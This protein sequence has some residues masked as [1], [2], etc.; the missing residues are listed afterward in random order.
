MA[1]D[2]Q[3]EQPEKDAQPEEQASAAIPERADRPSPA[4]PGSSDTDK[5]T[6]LE[7]ARLFGVSPRL[8][9]NPPPPADPPPPAPGTE[10]GEEGEDDGTT[11][12]AGAGALPA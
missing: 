5:A 9:V 3:P 1:T 7:V 2:D 4:K 8:L 11:G 12:E 10:D 6:V